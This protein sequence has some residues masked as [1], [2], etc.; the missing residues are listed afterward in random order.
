M[1]SEGAF[2][3]GLL[4]SLPLPL[5]TALAS[6][7]MWVFITSDLVLD[8]QLYTCAHSPPHLDAHGGLSAWGKEASVRRCEVCFDEQGEQPTGN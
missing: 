2:V 8:T 3:Q 5:P 1:G 6:L 4:L 7:F